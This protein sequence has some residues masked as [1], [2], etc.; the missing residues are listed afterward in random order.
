MSHSFPGTSVLN[1][2]F[3]YPSSGPNN[4]LEYMA[5]GLPFVTTSVATATPFRIDFPYITSEIYIQVSGAAGSSIRVGF[6]ENGVNNNNYF[7]VENTESPVTMRIRC[8]T[9]WIRTN[10]GTAPSYSVLGALTQIPSTS[11]PVLTGSVAD[12]NTGRYI[13]NSSS[14]TNNFGYNVLG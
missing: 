2:G 3:Q 5:S 6:T 4:T 13:F 14:Q 10:T 11:F 9:L 8:K 7:A 12:P 1:G